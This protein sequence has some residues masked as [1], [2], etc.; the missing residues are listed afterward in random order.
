MEQ[1]K[2]AKEVLTILNNNKTSIKQIENQK[3]NYYNYITDTI[4]LADYAKQK[5]LE[6]TNPFCGNLITICHEC[7]HSIQS[8][9][10]HILNFIF[11]NLSILLTIIGII[12][13]LFFEQADWVKILTCFVISSAI[14][15]R[16][17]LEI[18]AIRK[19]VELAEKII[20]VLEIKSISLNDIKF[21]K[22]IIKR[23]LPIQIIRM[24]I[25]KLIM[26]V[27]ICI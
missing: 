16:S 10:L 1:E 27:L 6:N 21:S 17:I 13:K 8:R 22:R 18:S 9:Y 20:N 25:D 14:L 26:L 7:I 3:T 11:S 4:Y 15:T 5:G 12:T 2:I 24:N 23:L 19:S